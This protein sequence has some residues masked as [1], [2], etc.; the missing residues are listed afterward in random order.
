MEP[1]SGELLRDAWFS[2]AHARDVTAKRP[3]AR[4]LGGQPIVLWRDAAG[5]IRAL[6]DRCCHRRVPLSAG[7]ANADGLL[8]CPY[9]G[10][11]YDGEGRVARIPSLPP[12]RKPPAGFGV[13]S[14]PVQV[15]YGLVWVWWGEP[16]AADE[17]LVPEIP[18]LDPEREPPA[19][20]RFSYDAPAELSIE[21]LLD[22]THLDFVH[23]SVFGDP[24]GGAE[25]ITVEGSDE[26]LVMRRVSRGRRPPKLM[27]PLMGFPKRQDIVQTMVVHVRSGAAYGIAWNTPPGW[28]VGIY[29]PNTPET[30]ERVRQDGAIRIFGPGWYRA[31]A[32]FV[33]TQ[34]VTRQ[35]NRIFRLQT[36]RY[37]EPDPRPDRSVP[38]DAAGLRYRQLR[39]QL[40]A[41]QAAGDFAYRPGW[42]VPN[43]RETLFER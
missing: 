2:L 17:K 9:H 15:R 4:R 30:P 24:F 33:A 39:A 10:W 23:G 22:L 35:D 6:E 29:V 34:V 5:A 16:A 19:R 31:L 28:G 38:A 37:R 27:A 14:Y 20:T 40:A 41:R 43:L 12:E 42:A 11:C 18:F 32:P 25:E 8:Q 13:A 3:L 36:P 7:R 26:V 21:N 1:M